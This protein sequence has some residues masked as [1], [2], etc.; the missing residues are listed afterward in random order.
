MNICEYSLKD[1]IPLQQFLLSLVWNFIY[2][3][4]TQRWKRPSLTYNKDPI[5]VNK[6]LIMKKTL[7]SLVPMLLVLPLLPRPPL[8]PPFLFPLHCTHNA[9][10][11]TE[12]RPADRRWVAI[13]SRLINA[14]L[15]HCRRV[16]R[17]NLSA[18][19]V[20]DRGEFTEISRDGPH[21]IFCSTRD[22]SL[23]L[24]LLYF[25]FKSYGFRIIADWEAGG[26]FETPHP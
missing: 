13:L 5:I 12:W 15:S 18:V 16:Y 3:R 19:P 2:L 25:A 17:V 24:F 23:S 14:Q 1:A 11:T 10:N 22:S 21:F 7:H 6:I 8:F 9:H 4:F 26:F 20:I